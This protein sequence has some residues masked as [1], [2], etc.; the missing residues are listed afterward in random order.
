VTP[1]GGALAVYQTADAMMCVTV[2]V[3]VYPETPLDVEIDGQEFSSSFPKL[4]N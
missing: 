2:A 3:T 1:A 4:R